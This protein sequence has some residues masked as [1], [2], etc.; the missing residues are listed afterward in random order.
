MFIL[1][2]IRI[3]RFVVYVFKNYPLGIFLFSENQGS[4]TTLIQFSN[5]LSKISYPRTPSASG[6]R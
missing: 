5:F 1:R 4:K 6:N 2:F 3:L